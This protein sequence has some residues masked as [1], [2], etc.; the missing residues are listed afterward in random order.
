MKKITVIVVVLTLLLGLF[1]Q[2]SRSDKFQIIGD[3]IYRVE[4]HEKLVAL[5]FDDGPSR[6]ATP[7]ILDILDEA[8]IKATFYLVGESMEKY[9][10]HTRN[11]VNK[12]HEIGNHSYS[13]QRMVF[14]TPAF[15]ANEIET[16]NELIR[17]AGYA[18]EIHFRPPYGKK[19]FTLPYYLY[20]QNITTVIWD[21]EPDSALDKDAS[22]SQLSDYAINNTQP[23]SIILMHVMFKSRVNSMAAV[24]A[25]I[26][27][28]QAKGYRFVTVSE[29]MASK[30][31]Q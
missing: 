4:T 20:K 24:P 22:P 28:L 11:I 14:K 16:T 17:K 27:G 12:G 26:K 2:V 31:A 19:L 9:F 1:W 18:D 29:L 25:I 3:L 30:S 15:V 5:T 23:G 7:K 6:Q 21:V 10:E 13:H 8:N